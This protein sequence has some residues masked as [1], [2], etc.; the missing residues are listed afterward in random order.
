MTKRMAERM[1][2]KIEERIEER[3]TENMTQDE[4]RVFLI[5]ELLSELPQYKDCLLYTSGND[6]T[7]GDRHS[8]YD[9]FD[10]KKADG[11]PV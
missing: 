3:R 6:H 2:E 9:V 4:K 7:C 5:Q 1:E 8:F 10:I 11:A